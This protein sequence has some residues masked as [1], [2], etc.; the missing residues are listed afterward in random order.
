[1]LA[2]SYYHQQIKFCHTCLSKQDWIYPKFCST[3]GKSHTNLSISRSPTSHPD[4]TS[5]HQSLICNITASTSHLTAPTPTAHQNNWVCTEKR[6][7]KNNKVLFDNCRQSLTP[8][9]SSIV[10]QLRQPTCF[11]VFSVVCQGLS[12]SFCQLLSNQVLRTKVKA[13][14]FLW[15]TL[16]C[17]VPDAKPWH[18][19]WKEELTGQRRGRPQECA[20]LPRKGRFPRSPV[21]PWTVVGKIFFSSLLRH[22]RVVAS[23][24]V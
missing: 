12:T 24:T 4:F 20:S 7:S 18:L 13:H 10:Q 15:M 16:C 11:L 5:R 6:V 1:M 9:I 17:L 23:A 21:I 8:H 19:F 14:R 3:L 2:C 22:P